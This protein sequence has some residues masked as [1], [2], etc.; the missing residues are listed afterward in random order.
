MKPVSSDGLVVLKGGLVVQ[1]AAL[2]LGWTLEKRGFV[3][4]PENGRLRV[5]P[6]EHLTPD[7]IAAIRRHRDE[8]L[9]LV[10]DVPPAAP[11]LQ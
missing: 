4:S 6:H 9:A 2:R 7:D 3:L 1:L 10:R 5:C 11:D 8:L